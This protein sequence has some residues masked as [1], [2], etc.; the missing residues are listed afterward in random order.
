MLSLARILSSDKVQINALDILNCSNSHPK[1]DGQFYSPAL[2]QRIKDMCVTKGE[3]GKDILICLYESCGGIFAGDTNTHLWSIHGG[4]GG[5]KMIEC[6]SVTTDNRGHLFV[7]NTAN[8]CIQVFSTDG[9]YLG[10]L[11]EKGGTWDQ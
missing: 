9:V 6:V 8:Q 10:C 11:V 1:L 5:K 3:D 7:C 4:V 2:G